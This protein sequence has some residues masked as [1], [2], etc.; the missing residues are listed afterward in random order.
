MHGDW[1]AQLQPIVAL[2][3]IEAEYIT[4]TKGVKEAMWLKGLVGELEYVHDKVE[5]FC[6]N[7]SSIYLAKN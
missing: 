2:S 3:K 6:N 7:Q 5:V 1:K 4:T